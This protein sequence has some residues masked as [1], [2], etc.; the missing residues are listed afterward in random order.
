[1]APFASLLRAAA[2]LA[3]LCALASAS[4]S[5]SVQQHARGT[6]VLAAVALITPAEGTPSRAWAVPTD[7]NEHYATC[8]FQQQYQYQPRKFGDPFL[9]HT[10]R[11]CFNT[12]MSIR[13]QGICGSA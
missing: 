9:Q 2:A 3:L 6:R 7:K 4:A 11:L 1:M 5:S 10:Y 8:A 13:I 12:C